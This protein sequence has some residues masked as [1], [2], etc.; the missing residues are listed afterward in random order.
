MVE[1]V[2]IVHGGAWAV[3]EILWD[4]SIAGVKTAALH[5]YKVRHIH[6]YETLIIYLNDVCVIHMLHRFKLNRF[7]IGK[8]FA[9]HKE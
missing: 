2:V 5:G 7:S 1:P 4:R 6:L 8:Y 3:P 9:D